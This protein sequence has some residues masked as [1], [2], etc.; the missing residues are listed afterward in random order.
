MLMSGE[1]SLVLV[2]ATV[3]AGMAFGEVLPQALTVNG[4]AVTDIER[5]SFADGTAV[6]YRLPDG[7][8][9]IAGED[10]VWGANGD[11]P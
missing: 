9:H 10:T 3:L 7:A 2:L 8:R 1:K 4:T 11:R 5:R 6:R